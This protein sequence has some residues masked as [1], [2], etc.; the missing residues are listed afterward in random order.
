V[1]QQLEWLATITPESVEVHHENLPDLRKRLDEA[2]AVRAALAAGQ[3]G[4]CA[5]PGPEQ[6][7]RLA[8]PAAGL[9]SA[10]T[11][12]AVEQAVLQPAP[13][14]TADEL[15]GTSAPAGDGA[16]GGGVNVP[17][18]LV[19]PSSITAAL[20]GLLATTGGA[21]ADAVAPEASAAA[22]VEVVPQTGQLPAHMAAAASSMEEVG[23]EHRAPP[24][25]AHSAVTLGTL[26]CQPVMTAD[27]GALINALLDKHTSRTGKIDYAGMAAEYNVA[28]NEL[29]LA[30]APYQIWPKT[31]SQLRSYVQRTTKDTR[32]RDQLIAR[33][34]FSKR[35]SGGVVPALQAIAAAGEDAGQLEAL[36][37]WPAAALGST[38][39]AGAAAAAAAGAAGGGLSAAGQVEVLPQGPAAAPGSSTAAGGLSAAQ[40]RPAGNWLTQAVAKRQRGEGGSS[41]GGQGAAG[42]SAAGAA[43]GPS[44][45]PAWVKVVEKGD[46]KGEG[47]GGGGVTKTCKSC[48]EHFQELWLLQ[49]GE[50]VAINSLH[51]SNCPWCARCRTDTVSRV[52]KVDCPYNGSHPKK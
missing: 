39:A 15:A 23:A 14:A 22:G 25:H 36:P 42:A 37:Q 19:P 24:T 11:P 6:G 27:E 10:S 52:R 12:A 33:S 43:A 21:A 40:K 3:H 5:P 38:A 50:S 28:A 26:A 1:G 29:R 9:A 18:Q 2:A 4:V 48:T 44:R 47:R 49:P 51:T 41:D 32:L 20:G 34:Q 46:K 8:L 35:S 30:R 7:S 16:D 17:L 31:A 13:P 45:L